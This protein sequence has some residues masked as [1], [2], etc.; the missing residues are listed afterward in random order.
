MYIQLQLFCILGQAGLPCIFFSFD[1][2]M[3][4]L[5]KFSNGKNIFGSDMTTLKY[6]AST[7]IIHIFCTIKIALIDQS[8]LKKV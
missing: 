2:K 7:L 5:F 1:F 6:S 3:K 8:L 4:L